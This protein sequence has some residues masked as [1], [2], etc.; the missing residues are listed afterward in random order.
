MRYIVYVSQAVKAFS[1]NDLAKLLEHS[2]TSNAK[3][4]ITGLLIYR[5]NADYRRGNFLQVLEGTNDA[6]DDVWN[7]ISNDPRLHTLVVLDGGESD[8]KMFGDWSMGFKNV[9]E[10]DLIEFSGFS[11]L[12]SDA[13]WKNANKEA[14]PDALT[15]LRSFY[16]G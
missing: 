12:G 3:D 16:E 13:F 4:G 11:E 15:T 14:L 10:K 2:R 1:T 5:Y 7:R 8:A 9:D 6:L